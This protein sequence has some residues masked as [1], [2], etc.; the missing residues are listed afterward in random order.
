MR[1]GKNDKNM[2]GNRRKL[3]IGIVRTSFLIIGGFV[4]GIAFHSSRS[5]NAI[6]KWEKDISAIENSYAG[7][8]PQ[9]KILFY[10]SSSIRLWDSMAEDL[11]PLETLNHGF[12]GSTLDDAIYY[13]DRMVIPFH[14]KAVVL[15]S[16]TNDMGNNLFG[17]GKDAKEAYLA[18][19]TLIT[20]LQSELPDMKIYYIASSPQPSRWSVWD[21]MAECNALVKSYC[22][23]HENVIYIDTEP[24]LLDENKE[25]RKELYRKDGLHFNEAGYEVW[26]SVI[27]PILM[28]DFS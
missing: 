13:A 21:R 7:N 22:E 25:L 23:D 18:T 20:Y 26:T 4:C 15:Y 6:K 5:G 9:G 24:V 10:G 28:E 8:Y 12:G 14:P 17:Q 11:A 2:Q 16:G 3:V 19:K 27:R 1:K